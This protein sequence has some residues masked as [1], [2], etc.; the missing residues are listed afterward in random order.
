M[1]RN[2][3]RRWTAA[4]ASMTLVALGASACGSNDDS[5]KATSPD[6]SNVSFTGDPI[7]VM[8][9]SSWG[10]AIFDIKDPVTIAQAAVDKIN[11]AG[12]IAGHKVVLDTC[13]DGADANS[14][15]ACAREAVAN[16]DIAYVG[17]ISINPAVVGPILEK[18]GIPWLGAQG[19]TAWDLANA[20]SYPLVSGPLA[21]GALAIRAVKDGCK[22]IGVVRYDAPAAAGVV[23]AFNAALAKVGAKVS[24]DIPVPPTAV[25]FDSIAAQVSKTDCTIAAIPS[26]TFLGVVAAVRGSG[27]STKFYTIA[28]TANAATLKAG[29]A[30][31]DGVVTQVNFPTEEDPVWADAKAAAPNV[32]WGW[33]YNDSTWASYQTL[34]D[35]LK[36]SHEK[37]VDA[38][39]LR[40]ALD[41]ATAAS[42]GGVTPP[43]N[44]TKGMP[45]PGLNRIFNTTIWFAKIQG[46]KVAIDG[47][48]VNLAA[49]G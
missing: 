35:V 28:G 33:I 5:S 13:N 34:A 19:V 12:G 21:F 38:A 30:T 29:G 49:A 1:R 9:T 36:N 44:F 6:L 27:G 26:Q 42:T 48:S 32:D 43:I 31:L 7:K 23:A 39:A 41:H 11:E 17:G 8:T 24:A 2:N 3:S 22:N 46:G 4:A 20:D 40:K 47:P 10:N 15:A 16:K 14:A 45:V 37:T 25:T 18:G